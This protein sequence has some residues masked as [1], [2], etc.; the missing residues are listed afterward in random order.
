MNLKAELKDE[1]TRLKEIMAILK[2]SDLIRGITPEKLCDT[3]TK[4]GPTYIKIGQIMSSRLDIIPQEYCREL[5][6]LRSDVEPMSFSE[7]TEILEEELGD[8][9]EIFSSISAQSIGSASM[10]QVHRARLI[11]GEDVAIKVQ[12]RNV[13]ETMTTDIRILKRAIK[14]LHLNSIIK[15]VDLSS[16]IDEIYNVA[17]EELNFEIEAKHLEEFR[18]NNSEI[19]C[20]DA[21]KV[22][23]NLVTK[24]VLVM[25]Y[26]NGI[27]LNEKKKLEDMGYDLKEIGLQIANNYLKQALD[28]GFFHADPHQGNISIKEDKIV[29]L[30]LGMM[31]RI[32]NHSKE[33]LNE[34]VKAFIKNDIVEIE[35]I[36]LSLSSTKEAVN[37][38]KL[39]ADI[40]NV[41]DKYAN[42]DIQNIDI[43]SFINSVSNVL[44]NHKI[45]LDK[46]ITMLM[47]GI[48]VIEGTLESI[49]PDINLIMVLENKIKENRIRDLFSKEA[50]INTGRN[51]V[52]GVSSTAELP[53]QLLTFLKDVNR[54]ETKFDIEVANSD[55]QVDKLEKMLHQLVIGLLDAAVLL[56]A[57]MVNN[58]VLRW[59]YVALS[60]V[61]TIW[62]FIQM[63]KDHFHKG[64]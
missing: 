39:R 11:T 46:N 53:T 47:R 1:K 12:R 58:P 8:I 32:S 15:V 52:S 64:Y 23:E 16:T 6:K 14:I 37:H 7:V 31:G 25:E 50:I 19:D 41:M 43:A 59:L 40:Q 5:A 27:T 61:F 10:A 9:D 38:T 29:F 26:V 57:S 51:I 42:E 35:H 54:G 22:Y 3:L 2:E 4:M 49:A 48:C 18:T 55:K 24:K 13:Y 62:L 36:L 45:R 33:L 60:V 63:A 20:V 44:K 34:A 56:G 28:D 21:P 30:D 17:K